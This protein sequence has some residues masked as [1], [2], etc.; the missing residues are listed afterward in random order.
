MKRSTLKS[1]TTV[2]IIKSK[3]GEYKKVTCEGHADYADAGSDIVCCAISILVINTINSLEKL[4]S[5]QMEVK[6]NEDN[7]FIECIFHDSLDMGSV[8]LLDS[9]VL[10]LQSVVS[11]YGKKYLKLKFREV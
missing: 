4:T 8:L 7:G 6:S 1:M 11:Q 5:T 3:N 10:G 2:T 9:M